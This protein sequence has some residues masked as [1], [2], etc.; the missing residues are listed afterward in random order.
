MCAPISPS[1]GHKLLLLPGS[2]PPMAAEILV[3]G[4]LPKSQSL[5][6]SFP[7][8]PS[9]NLSLSFYKTLTTHYLD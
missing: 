6:G 9:L 2:L 4:T 5:P 3:L 1:G 7:D 8:S